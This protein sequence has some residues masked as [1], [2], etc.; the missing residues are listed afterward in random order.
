MLN[1][2]QAKDLSQRLETLTGYDFEI[3]EREERSAGNIFTAD[4]SMSKSFQARLAARAL[5]VPMQE[6]QELPMREYNLL[7][8][9]V[10]NFLFAHL[11][12][13]TLSTKSGESPST[14]KPVDGAV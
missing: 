11:E 1:M 14:S 7:A 6:I 9:Q 13:G 10:F 12:K 8:A 3:A 4:I 2:E 5:S